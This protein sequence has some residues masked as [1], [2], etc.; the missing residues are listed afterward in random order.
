VFP[1]DFLGL[2]GSILE[3]MQHSAEALTNI[4]LCA[5]PREKLWELYSNFPG[6]AFNVT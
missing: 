6:L 2:Q 5:F 4:V 1:G 3:E